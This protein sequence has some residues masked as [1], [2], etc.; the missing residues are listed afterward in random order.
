MKK[1]ETKEELNKNDSVKE[2]EKNKEDENKNESKTESK[3]ESKDI[4]EIKVD[5]PY[6]DSSVQKYKKK[7]KVV[8]WVLISIL[9]VLGLTYIGGV[10]YF[11]SHFDSDT[12]I[13]GYDISYKSVEEVEKIFD[14]EFSAYEMDIVY[15][16]CVEKVCCG[17]GHLAFALSEDVDS[18]KKKQNPFLWFVNIFNED[19]FSVE[20]I[21][22]YDETAL[23][24]YLSSFECMKPSNMIESVNA[25]VRM[26]DGEV[27][28]IP[29]VTKTKLDT[30]K[31]YEVVALGLDGYEFSVDID[32]SDCY[33]KADITADSNVIKEMADNAEAFLSME[34]LYDFN[35]FMVPISREDLSKMG[36]INEDGIICISKTNVEA[37]AKRFAEKYTTTHSERVFDTHDGE[38]ILIYGEY[39]GWIINA[40]EEAVELYELLCTKQ[41]FVKKPVTEKEGYTMCEMNDIGDSY[42]EIDFLEQTLYVYIDG[43]VELE[44]PVV[45]GNL[46]LGY[47]T[48]GGLYCID[49][50]VYD[51][52]LV[53]PTWDLHVNMWMGF[54]G[55]IGMHD[56][57]WRWEYGGDIYT[58]NGSHG[59]VNIP[60]EQAMEAI[61]ICETGMPV[62]AYWLDEVEIIK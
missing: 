2:D 13:N 55:S 58:Y 9:S 6:I 36:Y 24:E 7:K 33:I 29:D 38:K 23:K 25:D 47:K 40:E 45:T 20:Y 14:D 53:G 37:F 16:D 32:A 48:P 46:A 26:K 34:A 44:T 28:I 5:R 31:V 12:Y 19:N 60:Y 8:K 11:S 54:N 51:T 35:G 39:Y 41:D 59:C 52:Q 62:V 15:K 18:I 10:I 50:R 30:D 56:A 42:V 22:S 4:P 3:T 43:K 61:G 57:P 27:V 49:N 21:A 17:D 1:E